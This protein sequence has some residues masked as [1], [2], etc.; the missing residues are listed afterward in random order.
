MGHRLVFKHLEGWS[1]RLRGVEGEARL[2]VILTSLVFT[3]TE[4][5]FVWS[6]AFLKF[7][8]I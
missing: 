6:L 1:F 3:S 8:L 5:N 2:L 7:P 4:R